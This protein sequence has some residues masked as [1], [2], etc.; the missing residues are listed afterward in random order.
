MKYL[1]IILVTLSSWACTNSPTTSVNNTV[2][3]T[4]SPEAQARD[5]TTK[6]KS[7]LELSTE[8]EEKVLMINVVNLK[9]MKRLRENNETEKL[10]STRD[11]YHSEIKVVLNEPQFAKF[12]E[13]FKEM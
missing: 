1:L 4:L 10:N 3:N 8:Q 13:E 9:V 11:K 6:M 5:L 2:S 7:S 12:L